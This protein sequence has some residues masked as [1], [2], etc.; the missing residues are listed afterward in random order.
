MTQPHT[1]IEA[2]Q[3]AW[4]QEHAARVSAEHELGR[5]REKVAQLEAAE[6]RVNDAQRQLLHTEKM[7]SLGQLAA[8]VAHEINNPVGFVLSNLDTLSGYLEGLGR[9]LAIHRAAT[10]ALAP[11]S[12]VRL[13]AEALENAVEL[14]Y[15]L[16][17]VPALLAESQAGLTRIRDIIYDLRNFARNDDGTHAYMNFNACVEEAVRIARPRWKHHVEIETDLRPLPPV[18]GA[19]GRI[20][21]V[22]LNL[23]VNAAQAIAGDGWIRIRTRL[24]DGMVE[25]RVTDSGPGVPVEARDTIFSPFFTTKPAGEGTGLGLAVSAGII[26]RHAGTIAVEGDPGEGATFVVRIPVDHRQADSAS[27]GAG[28]GLASG[29]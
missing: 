10:Q 8:G 9:V 22:F 3:R 17:D 27:G 16:E 15:L 28:T 21:Q 4:D 11:N 26:E 23:I 18:Y 20:L 14:E 24:E 19:S 7:A 25:A 29:D 13:E 5:L 6:Q 1:R 12:P 2:L